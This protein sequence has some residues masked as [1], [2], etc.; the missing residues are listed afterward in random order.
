VVL[1]P[2]ILQSFAHQAEKDNLFSAFL[3][4]NGSVAKAIIQ[5]RVDKRTI[6]R[7]QIP[8]S[9]VRD[10]FLSRYLDL[11]ESDLLGHKDAFTAASKKIERETGK[12]FNPDNI[13]NAA[14]FA[15]R[16]NDYIGAWQDSSIWGDAVSRAESRS[17]RN[18][19]A[20]TV[21]SFW[22]AVRDVENYTSICEGAEPDDDENPPSG[23][24]PVR[25]GTR[26]ALPPVAV[27]AATARLNNI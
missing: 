6:R 5:K 12:P 26:W 16:L 10:P 24:S 11:S 27:G 8:L 13:R 3:R 17:I 25:T 15:V 14:F 19:E 21:I 7:W 18:E 4:N 2:E 1:L 9:R 22:Q 23:N 20:K